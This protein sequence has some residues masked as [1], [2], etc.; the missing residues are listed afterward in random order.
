[1]FSEPLLSSHWN[2]TVERSWLTP[3]LGCPPR[4]LGNQAGD[5]CKVV[6]IESNADPEYN[7]LPEG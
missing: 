4:L 1:M 5:R 3:S 6:V 7:L 2:W